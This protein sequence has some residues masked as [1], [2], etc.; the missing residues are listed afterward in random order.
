MTHPNYM[1]NPKNPPNPNNTRSVYSGLQAAFGVDGGPIVGSGKPSRLSDLFHLLSLRSIKLASRTSTWG[2]R[3]H[4]IHSFPLHLIC[5]QRLAFAW[6]N[7]SCSLLQGERGRSRLRGYGE[8]WLGTT[9]REWAGGRVR[10][11]G[12]GQENRL[13]GRCKTGLRTT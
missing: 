11:L 3:S 5:A 2:P 9:W 4:V 1:N 13:A 7:L 8:R 6:E 10:F 12:S